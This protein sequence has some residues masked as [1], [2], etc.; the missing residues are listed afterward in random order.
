MFD[1]TA[2]HIPEGHGRN[3]VISD[4]TSHKLTTQTSCS[5]V[6]QLHS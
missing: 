1:Y 5:E 3:N 6:A 4:L 2:I